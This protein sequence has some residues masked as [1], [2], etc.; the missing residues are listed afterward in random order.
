MSRW[1]ACARRHSRVAGLIQVLAIGM[2][3]LAFVVLLPV[4]KRG[5]R[6]DPDALHGDARWATGSERAAM[7]K[8]WNSVSIEKPEAYPCRRRRQYPDRIAA[9]AR[10]N[11]GTFG[12]QSC[13]C[14]RERL[15]RTGSRIDPK[16][17]PILRLPNVAVLCTKMSGALTR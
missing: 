15:E 16:V 9:S 12:P 13:G 7:K 3:P 11:L 6:R 17:R 4:S 2:I 10:Q 8:V 5:P 1:P 14:R